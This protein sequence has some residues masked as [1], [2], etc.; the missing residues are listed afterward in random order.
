MSNVNLFN[1]CKFIVESNNNEYHTYDN[2]G[3]YITNTDCIGEPE[4][5]TNYV[6][7]PGMNGQLDMSE[8]LTGYPTYIRRKLKIRLAG[9]REKT[10]WD[11]I[12]SAFR[13]KI[14]GRVCHIIFD[15]DL[16]YYWRGRVS[17]TDFSSAMTL[18]QFTVDVEADPYKYSLVSSAEPWLWDPFNFET[19]SITYVGAWEINGSLTASVPSGNMLT[20]PVF[21][22]S[23]IVG[24][25]TMTVDNITYTM[26]DGSN[27]FPEVMVG[28]EDEVELSFSGIGTIQIVYRG[29]SL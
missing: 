20:C 24:S 18:G 7:V 21:V 16:N 17:I 8:V 15:N 1:G 29:G 23:D 25:L 12:I 28:G 14:N 5:Y 6:S 19:D 9:I 27:Q 3:L 11:S 2:W 4:Q 13:N 22:A 26:A 10:S